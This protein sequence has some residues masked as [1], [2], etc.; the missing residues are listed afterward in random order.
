MKLLFVMLGLLVLPTSANAASVQPQAKPEAGCKTISYVKWNKQVRVARQLGTKKNLRLRKTSPCLAQYKKLKRHV[1]KLRAD[2]L[3]PVHE[4]GKSLGDGHASHYGTGDGFLGG[5]LACGGT[6]TMGTMG[7]AHKTIAC[8][9]RIT[10]KYGSNVQTATVVDRGPFIAGRVW[11]LTPALRNALGFG[12]V[13]VVTA[14]YR[15]CWIK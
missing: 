15:N 1:K 12:D 9:T 5:P 6:L 8:G 13:G 4:G 7:V 3:R 14:A 2:C 10:F 11:D